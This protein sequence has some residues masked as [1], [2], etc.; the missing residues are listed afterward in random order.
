MITKLFIKID[1]RQTK[2]N[3]N[4]CAIIIFGINLFG[5]LLLWENHLLKIIFKFYIDDRL[6]NLVT[7]FLLHIDI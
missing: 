5:N 4:R 2:I 3:Y 7:I 6:E 1:S